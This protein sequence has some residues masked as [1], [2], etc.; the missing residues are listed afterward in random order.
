MKKLFAMVLA[1]VMVFSA[2]P[3]LGAYAEEA[4]I[5]YSDH[6]M[7]NSDTGYT[8]DITNASI[9]WV[10]QANGTLVWV[11][12]GDNRSD[13]E[14]IAQAKAADP[15]LKD[16]NAV[17]K[18]FGEAQTPN[19]NGAKAT[20]I[21][22]QA[23]GKITLTIDGKYSHFVSGTGA[24]A[25]DEEPAVEPA[26]DPTEPVAE[27]TEA[28]AVEGEKVQIRIDVPQKMAVAFE[29]GTVYYGGEMKEVVYN[30]EYAFQMCSVNWENGLFDDAENG[31]RGTVVYR[32]EV[33][34]RNEFKELAAAAKED[35]ERYTVKGIDIIDNV[36]KKII[37]DGDATDTHLETD[38]NN[39]FMAY[40][41]HFEGQDY[42]HK[43][44]IDKVVNKPLESLSVNLPLGSTITCKAFVG[45]EQI[46]SADVFVAN[47]S[48]EGVYDD[49]FLTSV[50]DFTWSKAVEEVK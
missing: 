29:D 25:A 36:A 17:L 19:G 34:H 44:G 43:T 32:M 2:V 10:K 20:V 35:P 47:N 45:D 15:S 28:P 4:A 18:G 6:L 33:V 50:N 11:P 22:A 14:I 46:D 48:G 42:N 7:N 27:P 30:H 16:E 38:V 24:A 21:V 5:T 41:F 9:A 31:I 49:E 8:Y 37:I 1:L 40:R 26:A 12:A 3:V 13:D 39:F 23:D